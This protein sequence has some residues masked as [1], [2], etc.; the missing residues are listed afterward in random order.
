[1][2]LG[3]INQSISQSETKSLYIE[4]NIILIIIPILHFIVALLF[5]FAITLHF[6]A[7][8]VLEIELEYV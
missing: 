2:K 3:T 1:M 8:I 4:I 5:S 6:L 7:L